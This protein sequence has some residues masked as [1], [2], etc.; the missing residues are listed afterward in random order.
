MLGFE[1]LFLA[2]FVVRYFPLF[3]LFFL[4]VLGLIMFYFYVVEFA[5][6]SSVFGA[7][8]RHVSCEVGTICSA[9]SFY[10]RDIFLGETRCLCGMNFC[11]GFGLFFRFFLFEDSAADESIRFRFGGRFLMLG[12][13]QVSSKSGDLILA[14]PILDCMVLGFVR[15]SLWRHH[16]SLGDSIRSS[17]GFGFCPSFSQE[18]ARQPA[19]K[20]ARNSAARSSGGDIARRTLTGFFRRGEFFARFRFDRRGRQS[21][22]GPA[23]ILC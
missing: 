22:S 23:A 1:D 17:G 7:F 12:F 9:P 10:F 15:G 6:G 3:F 13:D 8:L 20:P 18:P 4:F 19:R 2:V 16:F 11:N 14:Q 21:D 5:E